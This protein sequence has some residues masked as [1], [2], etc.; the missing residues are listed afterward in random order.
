MT[1]DLVVWPVDRPLT[2]EEAAGD[3]ARLGGSLSFG[4]GHDKRLDPFIAA[5]EK[6]YPGLRG[7]GAVQPP[8]EFD[9]HRRQVFMGI[10][11]SAVEDVVGVVGEVAYAS[12]LAVYDPQREAVGLPAPFADA[13]MTSDGVEVHVRKA[14]E[15]F[16]AIQRGAAMSPGDDSADLE[17][18]ISGSSRRRAS[19]R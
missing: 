15:A 18:A 9:V 17:R 6:R 12:G 16:A 14:G 19:T 5:M 8:F 11:W 7:R 2:F 1:Y 3:V 13:P 10:S 4:R